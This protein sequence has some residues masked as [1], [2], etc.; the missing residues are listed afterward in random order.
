MKN[1]IEKDFELANKNMRNLALST[2]I[3]FMDLGHAFSELAKE[4]GKF[5][6][7]HPECLLPTYH[8]DFEK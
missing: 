2:S 4:Y 1:K 7:A 6:K 5:L 3:A 8:R